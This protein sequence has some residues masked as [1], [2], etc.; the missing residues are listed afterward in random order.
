[1]TSIGI[2]TGGTNTRIWDG[3]HSVLRRRTP[4]NYEDYLGLLEQVLTP[5]A[6][7]ELAVALPAVIENQRVIKAPNLSPAWKGRDLRKDIKRR[8]SSI[9]RILIVQ[10]TEAAGYAIQHDE[11]GD[12][13]PSLLLTLS[14]GVGGAL[15]TKSDVL[16]LELGHMPL[17][18]SGNW[19]L[20]SCGQRGCVEADLSGT[21]VFRRTGLKSESLTDTYFWDNYANE[22][23]HLLLVLI[24][25]FKLRQIVLMGGVAQRHD[26]FLLAA[27]KY[28]RQRL[29]NMHI[30]DMR[31]SALGDNAGVRG[32]YWLA[33]NH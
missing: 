25:L 27:S 15:V 12:K 4:L 20:C 5:F 26:E 9:E 24:S 29:R 22:F 18:L 33:V 19:A 1:M 30:P 8:I 16:V 31:L 13:E 32:A 2:D 21:A 23:G 10:D 28:V 3:H 17:N 11:L 7:K 6:P 14:T